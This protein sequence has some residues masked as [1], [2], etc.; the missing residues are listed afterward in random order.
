MYEW[1]PIKGYLENRNINSHLYRRKLKI[2]VIDEYI[3]LKLLDIGINTDEY[4]DTTVQLLDTV[5]RIFDKY[6]V[7]STLEKKIIDMSINIERKY[8]D[9][10]MHDGMYDDIIIP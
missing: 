8:N 3:E 5:Y 6:K 2:T 10:R 4:K 9:N 1:I 7:P